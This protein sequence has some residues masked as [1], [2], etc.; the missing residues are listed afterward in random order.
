MK[1]MSTLFNQRFSETPISVSGC[2]WCL[3]HLTDT[4]IYAQVL[5]PQHFRLSVLTVARL[6]IFP[7]R[8]G[9]YNCALRGRSWKILAADCSALWGGT[10]RCC[11]CKAFLV[12][13][14]QARWP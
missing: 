10:L 8:G 4:I 5:S 7:L 2:Q 9:V 1:R 3:Q 11:S 12:V 14:S 6:V 13:H